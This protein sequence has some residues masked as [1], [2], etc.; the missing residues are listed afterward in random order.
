M[1]A[2]A[3]HIPFGWNTA[4]PLTAVS[5]ATDQGD[6]N[7]EASVT[8]RDVNGAPLMRLTFTPKTPPYFTVDNFL[9]PS[10]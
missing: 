7:P 1:T 4:A 8:I 6:P 2:V 9:E 3:T 10:A 5:E